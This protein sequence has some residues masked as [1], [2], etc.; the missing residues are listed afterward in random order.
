MKTVAVLQHAAPEDL[1]TITDNLKMAGINYGYIQTFKGEPVPKNMD[2][3][4]GLIVMGGPQSVYEQGQFPYLKEELRLIGQA[5]KE[6]KPVLGICLGSQLLA[7]ALGAPVYKGKK[8][9]IGWLPIRLK[10]PA[11]SDPLFKEAPP[12]FM[13][14]HWH[15]DI[16]D[17]PKGAASLACSDLTEHQA[18][19][20]GKNAYGFLFHMEVTPPMIREWVSVFAEELKKE[21]LNGSDIERQ[22]G[23]NQPPLQKLGA[24]VYSDWA[25]LLTAP[26]PVR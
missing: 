25:G 6:E 8:K 19:R 2:R 7:A 4:D 22:T 24:S 9:E 13:G 18:F 1:G 21:G 14:F 23:K 15:G 12:S 26:Q 16:F 17:L 3:L 5:L 10:E 11:L 20:Y